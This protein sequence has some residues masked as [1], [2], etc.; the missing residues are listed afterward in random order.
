MTSLAHKTLKAVLPAAALLA[1]AGPALAHHAFSM[2]ALDQVVTVT[3]TVQRY[4]FRMPHVWIYMLANTPAGV[5]EE[6]GFEAHAPNLVAR[7][8]W[9]ISTL[10]PGDKITLRMHPMRDGSKAGSV[11]DITLADGRNL[12]NAQSINQP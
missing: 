1:F 10:K 6:W 3:G 9:N 4:D 7:K 12:W 5:Q 8:G 2:F 11:I